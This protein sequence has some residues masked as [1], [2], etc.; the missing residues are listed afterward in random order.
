MRRAPEN[1]EHRMKLVGHTR[2]VTG[3]ALAAICIMAL[4]FAATANAESMFSSTEV[5]ALSA[6]ALQTQKFNTD[7]GLVECTGLHATEGEAQRLSV[8]IRITVQYTGCKAF[9]L[10]ATVS[11]AL[12]LFLALIGR[13]H[14]RASVTINAGAGQCIVTV[15]SSKNQSLSTVKYENSGKNIVL[16]PEVTNISYEAAGAGCA[17]PGTFGDGTYEGKSVGG[18]ANGT[19]SVRWDA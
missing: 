7:E 12:Y 1:R 4:A 18:L 15:P 3:I 8:H 5:G 2:N 6:K 14:L 16:T 11:P 19:G 10:T 17:A 9:G 13:V